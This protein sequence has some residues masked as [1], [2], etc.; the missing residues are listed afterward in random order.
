MTIEEFDARLEDPANVLATTDRERLLSVLRSIVPG[1][2]VKVTANHEN[3]LVVGALMRLGYAS[4][5][6]WAEK[7]VSFVITTTGRTLLQSMEDG[8]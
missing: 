3:L 8:Q 2:G 7:G 6:G 4:S 1:S 5:R